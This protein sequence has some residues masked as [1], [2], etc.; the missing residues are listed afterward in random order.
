VVVDIDIQ[1]S[2]E[3]FKFVSATGNEQRNR[4]IS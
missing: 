3:R 4:S 2:N 1:T